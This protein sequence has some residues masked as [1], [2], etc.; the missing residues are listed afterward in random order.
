MSEV[1][2]GF[3][4]ATLALPPLISLVGFPTH[5]TSY[6]AA[7][8]ALWLCACAVFVPER[9]R[10]LDGIFIAIMLQMDVGCTLHAL[11]L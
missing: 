4:V 6:H 11:S 7:V 2:E 1:I 8:I 10:P 9:L 3:G 5:S